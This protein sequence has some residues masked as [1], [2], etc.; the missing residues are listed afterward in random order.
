MYR[1]F[2]QVL[3]GIILLAEGVE[4]DFPGGGFWRAGGKIRASRGL[5]RIIGG[6][7]DR[8]EVKVV[9]TVAGCPHCVD[10]DLDRGFHRHPDRV[11]ID[12]EPAPVA[13]HLQDVHHAVEQLGEIAPTFKSWS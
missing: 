2:S 13:V 12:A 10:I 1:L 3:T 6:I 5:V 7:D 8:F 4:A 11:D 9:D